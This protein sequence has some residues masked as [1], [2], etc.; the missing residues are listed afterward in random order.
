MKKVNGLY[1]YKGHNEV[2]EGQLEQGIKGY[3]ESNET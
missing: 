1:F 2:Q 3:F